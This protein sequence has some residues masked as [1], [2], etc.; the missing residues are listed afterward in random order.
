MRPLVLLF[1][2]GW[3]CAAPMASHA[4]G[5]P[6]RGERQ[7]Q[8]CF[9]CHSVDP[10]ETAK[11]QGPSLYRILGRPAGSVAGFDYSDAFRRRAAAGLVW[12]AATIAELVRDAEEMI[13]GTRMGL[14]PLRDEQDQADLIAY[15]ALAGRHAP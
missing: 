12:E 10:A 1:G 5:D 13:P 14:P 11:L 9:S 8:R 3:L 4:A 6:A 2:L 15:L 7:F